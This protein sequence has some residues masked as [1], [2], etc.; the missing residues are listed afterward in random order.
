MYTQAMYKYRAKIIG[1][2]R[3]THIYIYICAFIYRCVTCTIANIRA[4]T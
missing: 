3:F 1:T 2:F 4:Y